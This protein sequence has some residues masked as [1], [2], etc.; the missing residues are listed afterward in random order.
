MPSD[1]KLVMPSGTQI[2]VPLGAEIIMPSDSQFR[3]P[4]PKT[5]GVEQ[6]KQQDNVTS[7]LLLNKVGE[8]ASTPLFTSVNRDEYDKTIITISILSMLSSVA[9]ALLV[10]RFTNIQAKEQTLMAVHAMWQTHNFDM[11]TNDKSLKAYRRLFSVPP[12]ITDDYIRQEYMV[13]VWM[14]I[15]F[16]Q[17]ES[18]RNS[19]IRGPFAKESISD[20]VIR[21]SQQSDFVIDLLRDRGFDNE[22]IKY[23]QVLLNNAKS[24]GAKR[25]T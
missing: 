23:I 20:A 22:F 17:W 8:S 19:L 4:N 13:I 10:Y 7:S 5:I 6:S 11:L 1:I 21:L 2:V 16:M 3:P 12:S 25:T 18:D 15:I 24:T 9:L 14:N